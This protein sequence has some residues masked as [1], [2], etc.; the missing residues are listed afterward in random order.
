MYCIIDMLYRK[1]E[2]CIYHDSKMLAKN[3]F[4]P[5]DKGFHISFLDLKFLTIKILESKIK[6]NTINHQVSKYRRWTLEVHQTL[7]VDYKF[8]TIFIITVLYL[9]FSVC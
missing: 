2:H 8:K 4:T 1:R 9:P 3:K 5:R 6:Q 7:S